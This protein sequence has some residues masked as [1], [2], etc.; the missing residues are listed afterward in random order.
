MDPL[1]RA[2]ALLK[3]ARERGA[4]VVTPD[5]A[6]SPMDAA[7]TQQ[8]P[9]EVVRGAEAATVDP[10]ATTILTDEE[11][12]EQDEDYL[13]ESTPT[14]QIPAP[15]QQAGKAGGADGSDNAGEADGEQAE[16]E[17]VVEEHTDDLLPTTTQ[18]RRSTNVADRLNG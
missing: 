9:R 14:T 6:I 1:A 3:R 11:I 18:R 8:I 16:D 10:D 12:R 17:I 13:A 15:G 7:S 4:Y 2:E 5:N